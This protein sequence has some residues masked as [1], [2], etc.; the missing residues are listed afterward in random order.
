MLRLYYF[1]VN[2]LRMSTNVRF[3]DRLKKLNQN[4]HVAKAK[5]SL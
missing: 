3:F 2:S 1:S 5:I 4:I